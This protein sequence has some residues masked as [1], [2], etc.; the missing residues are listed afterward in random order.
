MILLDSD[1]LIE[2][3]RAAPLAIQWISSAATSDAAVP[4]IVAL[5]LMMGARNGVELARIEKFVGS[6]RVIGLSESDCDM[7]LRLVRRHRLSTGLGLPDYLIAAQA[8]RLGATVV[9]FNRKHFGAI[10]EL[11]VQVRYS[12]Q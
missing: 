7:A 2:V 9:T 12:R 10:P 3:E 5:E 11:D 8:I 1:V 4:G 6:F